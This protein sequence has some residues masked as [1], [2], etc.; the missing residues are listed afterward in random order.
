MASKKD[1]SAKTGSKT[2][3]HDATHTEIEQPSAISVIPESSV[4]D[5]RWIVRE[6]AWVRMFGRIEAKNP[7]AR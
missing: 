5:T 1:K 2:V 7:F 3:D 6:A 4:S